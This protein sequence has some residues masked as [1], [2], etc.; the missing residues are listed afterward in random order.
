MNGSTNKMTSRERLRR[1]YFHQELDRPGIYVRTGFPS[2][3]PTYDRVK[4]YLRQHTD[5]K[6][7][8]GI[9]ASQW[10]A[11]RRVEPVSAEWRRH[12]TTLHTPAGDLEGRWLESLLGLPGLSETYL[13]KTP[14]DAC[15]YLSLP[16]PVCTG[17]IEGFRKVDREMGERGI[18]EV[19]LGLNPAGA[20][21]ELFGQETFALLS[22]TDRPVLHELCRMHMEMV[23][24]RVRCALSL[25]MGPYFSMAGEEYLVP[26]L[27]G[28]ADFRDFNMQYDRPI[29][30]LIHN[31]GG[32][33]HIHCHGSIRKVIGGFVE[34]G[35]D[36]LHP[37]EAPPMGDIM[38]SEAKQAAGTRMTL[39]GN[40]QIADLYEK[41]PEFI[42]QSTRDLVRD[43]FADRQGLIVC[44]T[45]S[46]YQ[47][48]KGEQC[49]ENVVALVEAVRQDVGI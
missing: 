36:V 22:V 10:P 46:P 31:A 30:D 43:A 3:D 34:M 1:C 29:I 48:G 32:R 27:A 21:V 16:K 2:N 13:L 37:F 24:D 41:T 8:W 49:Y 33:V 28:P 35:V 18:V 12:V 17:D 15:K 20:V 19:G 45:A 42:R 11:D 44:P 6:G 25:G 39:E 7:G 5:L 47:R 38:P 40:L 26:P 4:A 14:K 23:L 9:L